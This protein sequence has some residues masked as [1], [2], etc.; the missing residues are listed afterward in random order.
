[1]TS[2][3]GALTLS[4][5]LCLVITKLRAHLVMPCHRPTPCAGWGLVDPLGRKMDKAGDPPH[6]VC[7]RLPSTTLH[8]L[9]P[10][11]NPGLLSRLSQPFTQGPGP[12]EPLQSHALGSA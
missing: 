3:S 8:E 7:V 1:M 4:I 11:G 5:W 2:T 6:C 10:H 12:Q 9:R